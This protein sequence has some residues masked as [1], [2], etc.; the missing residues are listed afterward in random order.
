M[1][2][3]LETLEAINQIGYL[4][5]KHGAEIYRI[6]ESLNKMCQGAGFQ[7][8]HIFAVPSYFT[9]TLTLKDGTLYT[10]S[11][12]SHYN[13][14]HLDHLY[15]LNNL[16]RN[17]S[18]N[19][20]QLSQINQEIERIQ[21]SK[22]NLTYIKIGYV[23][24]AAMFC[25]FFGGGI[26]ETILSGVIGYILYYLI[27]LLEKL[28]INSI[29]RTIISSM[30][31]TTIAIFAYRLQLI[32]NQHAAIIGSLMLLVPGLAITNSFRDIINGDFLSGL[33][34]MA[35]A[36]LI[37]ASIAIGVGIMMMILGG[38]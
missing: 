36:I 19:Q 6:E 37:A 23:I 28:G 4:L 30:V 24:S 7:N 15:D 17:V 20:L 9:I 16:V 22:L 34:R 27:Y 29:V 14:I 33:I 1:T 35:E 38:A 26:R 8:I 3:E 32:F 25:I 5:L 13:R 18:N 12:R 11:R 10:S 31:L 2:N 21:S